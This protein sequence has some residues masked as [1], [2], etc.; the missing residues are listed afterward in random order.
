MKKMSKRKYEE[1]WFECTEIGI[2]YGMHAAYVYVVGKKKSDL[3]AV[4]CCDL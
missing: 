3:V 2:T 4:E 1:K